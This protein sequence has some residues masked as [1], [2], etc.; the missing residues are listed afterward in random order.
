MIY[1]HAPMGD[2]AAVLSDTADLLYT[3]SQKSSTHNS[4]R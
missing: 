2:T 3:V 4:W 1:C